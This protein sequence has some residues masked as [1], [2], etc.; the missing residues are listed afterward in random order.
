MTKKIF[1]V[2][3]LSLAVSACESNPAETNSNANNA[4]AKAPAQA[5]PTMAPSP[6]A[7]PTSPNA[8]QLKAGDKVKIMVNGSATE[9]TVVSVDEKLGKVTIKVQGESKERTVAIADITRQ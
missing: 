5:S 3:L 9:A 8:A 1:A 7:E 4:N 6:S 2:L